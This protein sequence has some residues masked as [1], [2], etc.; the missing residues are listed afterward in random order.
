[1]HAFLTYLFKCMHAFT[2]VIK[3]K[4]NACNNT[5]L[6]G[7]SWVE[8]GSTCCFT[9]YHIHCITFEAVCM[10]GKRF[11]SLYVKPLL[12]IIAW[13]RLCNCLRWY[14]AAKSKPIHAF[15][16]KKYALRYIKKT[17]IQPL[18]NTTVKIQITSKLDDSESAIPVLSMCCFTS[19]RMHC[20]SF[21]LSMFGKRYTFMYVTLHTY[22]CYVTFCIDCIDLMLFWIHAFKTAII[23][24]KTTF[25]P[26]LNW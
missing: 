13:L 23:Q 8:H 4:L 3:K 5:L 17:Y 20:I 22:S 21:A 6:H 19:Y 10:F 26:N 18:Q 11:M 9:S 12:C 16:T 7:Y 1:M 15:K 14:C 2:D 24:A 25:M